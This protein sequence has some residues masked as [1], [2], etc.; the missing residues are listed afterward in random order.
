MNNGVGLKKVFWDFPVKLIVAPTEW[1]VHAIIPPC[2]YGRLV[3]MKMMVSMVMVV[4]MV[5][6]THYH[7]QALCYG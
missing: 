5:I 3:M 7:H 2:N 6:I 1:I 4:V